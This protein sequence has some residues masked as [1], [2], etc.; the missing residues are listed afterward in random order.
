MTT[1]QSNVLAM[2]RA[3]QVFLTALLSSP[4]ASSLFPAL[5]EKFATLKTLI[6]KI[7]GL[8][9]VQEAPTDG[10][11]QDREKSMV[12]TTDAALGVAAGVLSYA[13]TLELN[14]LIAK[15]EIKRSDF[16]RMRTAERMR[17]AQRV[18]DAA[19][20]LGAELAPDGVTLAHLTDLQRRIALTDEAVDARST[21][22]RRRRWPP[23]NSSKR[24][25][26]WT[27]CSPRSIRYCSP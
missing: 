25:T 23:R 20:P 17:L 21:P 24:S 22:A 12:E 2:L 10:L 6:P 13:R 5:A 8:A 18:H 1:I 15:V 16:D 9:A 11:I 7:A 27:A 14:D 3:V 4:T 19:L 26:R